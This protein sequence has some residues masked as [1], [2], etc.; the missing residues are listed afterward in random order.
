[1][2]EKVKSLILTESAGAARAI[3]KFAGST[4]SVISTE[5]FLK[6]LPRSR[7]GIDAENGYAPDYITVRGKGP[8]LTELRKKTNL[9][10]RIYLATNPNAAGEFLALQCCE[11]FGVNAKSNCRV[12]VD[13]FTKTAV[14]SAIKNARPIDMKLVDAFQTR[15]LIDKFISHRVG[16][17]L[18][19]KIFRGVKVGRF[20][21]MLLKLI[22]TLKPAENFEPGGALNF[23]TLQELSLAKLNFS[24]PKTRL[25][26]DQLYE[27]FDECGGLIK[28]PHGGAIRLTEN[29][30]E[31]DSV[32]DFLTE[33]QF[34]LYELIYAAATDGVSEKVALD[35]KISDLTVTAALDELG[36]GWAE[37]YSIGINSLLKRKYIAAGA[38]GYAVTDLGKRVLDALDGFFDEIFSVDTY[39]EIS[40]QIDAVAAGEADKNSVVAKY[41]DAFSENFSAAMESL[42]EDANPKDELSDEVCDKCGR[43]MIVKHGRYGTFLACS[44]YPECKNIRPHVDY[45]AQKC[46]KCGGRITRQTFRGG[47]SLYGCEKFPACDF[48]TWDDPLE[49][50]CRECGGTMFAHRFRGRASMVYCGN[51][52]CPTRQGHPINKI[53][54]DAKRR[55]EARKNLKESK[56]EN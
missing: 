35:G 11:L 34:K 29:V 54:D 53:L 25:L 16:E 43:P 20:R 10:G 17:Y 37:F 39:K 31:P 52:N 36:V 12:I 2:A 7:I 23:G 49:N 26:T 13:E 46:P 5:G 47:K 22:S 18:A 42:G 3:K 1:M 50:P 30:R 44:G 48:R 51:E 9:A 14:K 32:K 40:A 38:T 41:C 33:N 21:A 24:T 27:G 56:K 8:L 55:Y 4:Y 6:D 19:C 28:Y 45:L 15:Q